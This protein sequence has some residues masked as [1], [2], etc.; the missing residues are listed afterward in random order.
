MNIEVFLFFD[1]LRFC[2][3]VDM[4]VYADIKALVKETDLDHH[5]LA[6]KSF[7]YETQS[8]CS[9]GFKVISLIP[10]LNGD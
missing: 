4:V 1:E 9:V 6:H 7:D 2:S 3:R 5:L 8:S 10:E